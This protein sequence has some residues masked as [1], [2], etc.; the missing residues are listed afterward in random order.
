MKR[1]TQTALHREGEMTTM[2]HGLPSS[3]RTDT[4]ETADGA[5]Y[6]V[7]NSKGPF[8]NPTSDHPKTND[9]AY[10]AEVN[11]AL[12]LNLGQSIITPTNTTG[13]VVVWVC[14][15]LDKILL[16]WWEKVGMYVWNEIVPV[17]LK[18]RF[19]RYGW[20]AVH[21]I[22]KTLLGKRTGL[23]PTQSVEYHTFTSLMFLGPFMACTP[24]RMRFFLKELYINAPNDPPHKERIK[25]VS[26]SMQGILKKVPSEQKKH[27]TAQ[28]W[29]IRKSLTEKSKGTIFW[30]YGGAYLAGDVRG[31]SSVADWMAGETDMDVFM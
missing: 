29:F 17:R 7:C 12:N 9:S 20:P 4:Y 8:V 23:H 6:V 28:G 31:N 26:E 10:C 21:G 25:I 22:H 19:V 18:R 5:Q 14:R 2:T 1:N 16:E 3:G 15:F 24:R 11:G 13:K 30:I 27:M